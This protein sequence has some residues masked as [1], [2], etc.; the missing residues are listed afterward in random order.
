MNTFEK[1]W[2]LDIGGR[3]FKNSKELPRRKYELRGWSRKGAWELPLDTTQELGTQ[4]RFVGDRW[5]WSTPLDVTGIDS[6]SSDTSDYL[7]INSFRLKTGRN[8]LLWYR[9]WYAKALKHR[10]GFCDDLKSKEVESMI[11]ISVLQQE[12]GKLY[13][14]FDPPQ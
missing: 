10:Y 1:R 3:G 6:I 12:K 7:A 14:W 9:M 8:N 5:T 13:V 4:T 2:T 11:R